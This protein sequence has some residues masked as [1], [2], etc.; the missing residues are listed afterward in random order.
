M[1]TRITKTDQETDDAFAAMVAADAEP[2]KV[3]A[4]RRRTVDTVLVWSGVV[5]TVVLAV[6]GALLMWGSN[7]AED[8]VYDE[9]S[10][11]QIFFP[12]EDALVEEG[13]T[14]LVQYAE[15]QVTTGKEAEAY[16]SFIDGHLQETADGETY[17]TLGAVQR[18]ARAAVTEATEAGASEAE[19]AALQ[20]EL[21]AVNQQRDT[22]FRGETLRGL[23]LSAYAWSTVGQIAG[24]AAWVA[25][26]GAGAMLVMVVLGVVHLRRLHDKA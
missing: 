26:I 21:D 20:E 24:I 17:A 13:R 22:L 4:V 23:L 2:P 7:F 3:V 12:P 1:S 15:E 9:L 14:D 10:S 18:E 25:L 6:C 16:A 19:I 8:Y 11:Q 5:V